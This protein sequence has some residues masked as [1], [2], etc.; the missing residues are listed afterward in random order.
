[1]DD[2]Q[3]IET[4]CYHKTA[5]CAA[6]LMP[7]YLPLPKKETT[8]SNTPIILKS[9]GGTFWTQAPGFRRG[10]TCTV[11]IF[12]RIGSRADEGISQANELV[13]RTED[14][15]FQLV[16][17]NADDYRGGYVKVSL[18]DVR[19]VRPRLDDGD[20]IDV[21][22]TI[23]NGDTTIVSGDVVIIDDSIPLVPPKARE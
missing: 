3:L 23:T 14:V 6:V 18:G 15:V 10:D 19:D 13:F 21:V 2:E 4:A 12:R 22:I 20:V 8:M 7:P 9:G 16:D 5:D 17:G 1:L 11:K